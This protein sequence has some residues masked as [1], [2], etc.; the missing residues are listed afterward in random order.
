MGTMAVDRQG[1]Q[2]RQ[3]LDD[4]DFEDVSAKLEDIHPHFLVESIFDLFRDRHRVDLIGCLALIVSGVECYALGDKGNAAIVTAMTFVF[5][6]VVIIMG[7]DH[8]SEAAAPR[9]AD[10]GAT[11]QSQGEVGEDQR[12]D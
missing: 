5:A 6:V 2:Q 12:G 9:P 10:A 8:G 11:A 3:Y 7:R 1:L 4:G